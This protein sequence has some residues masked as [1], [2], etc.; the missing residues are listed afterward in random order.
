MENRRPRR[1][2][3][4][5][6][7][8]ARVAALGILSEVL[9]K[10]QTLDV[11]LENTLA[12]ELA[13]LE[14]RDRALARALVT[15]TLRRLGE[16]D[17]YIAMFLQKP[18]PAKAHMAQHVLRLGMAQLLFMK[19]PDH[20]A[21]DICVSLAQKEQGA[22]PFKKLINAVLR[23]GAGLKDKLLPE[24]E[25]ARRSTPDWLMESWQKAYGEK[26]LAIAA[27][28]LQEPPLDITLKGG[29]PEGLEGEALPT[30]SWR[31]EKSQDVRA[32]PGFE[33]G[34]FWVQ[35][36]AATLP[37]FLLGDVKDKE[38]L[39]LCAA[40]GGKT[41][42]LAAKGAH[43]TAVDRSAPRMARVKENLAR[44][45]LTA[46][47]IVADVEK[48]GSEQRF[49]H[50]LL[51]APCSATGTLR[52]H[53]DLKLLKSPKDVASLV[54]LQTRLLD[55]ARQSLA[56]GGTL[57]YCTCSLQPEEGEEQVA[58]FLARHKDM[59]RMPLSAEEFPALA[60]FI[61]KDGDLRT[62]PCDWPDK[63]GLDGFYAARLT[64]DNS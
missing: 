11:T 28:H 2:K 9:D 39:D 34:A 18:L 38:V 24:E 15:L 46:D 5:Q 16:L 4:T 6:G 23:K 21:V 57:V 43:V 48:L 41:L 52:R 17:H 12:K 62:L 49:A 54:D 26:A 61:N 50:I 36:A 59:K 63:G 44:T 64:C 27:A 20:A 45:K 8:A 31:L 25:A 10:K 58:A 13:K 29:A 1:R 37:V 3:P 35:D 47:V 30:G 42:Q 7:F 53:P 56:P 51:D 19:V 32:L 55:A 40:P 33:E 14:P 22:R 60:E